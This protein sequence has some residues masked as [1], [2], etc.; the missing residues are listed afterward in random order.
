MADQIMSHLESIEDSKDN[1]SRRKNTGINGA[2][3]LNKM[4]ELINTSS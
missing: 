2:L 1:S 3:V 4:H